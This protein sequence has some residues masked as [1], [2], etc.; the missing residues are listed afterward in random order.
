MNSSRFFAGRLARSQ[1][2][3]RIGREHADRLE[4]ARIEARGLGE[5]QMGDAVAELR[6][7]QQRVAVCRGSA[8]PARCRRG[9]RRRPAG[10]RPPPAG[11]A[12]RPPSRRHSGTAGRPCRR[13]ETARPSVIGRVGKLGLRRLSPASRQGKQRR[14]SGAG[15][16]RDTS[17]SPARTLHEA[18]AV[19]ASLPAARRRQTACDTLPSRWNCA[20]VTSRRT[21]ACA[22][23]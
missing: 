14:Q 20:V 23:L 12:R 7:A 19:L 1:D 6:A 8:A 10:S 22:F 21:S 13:P 5:H 11:R 2:D 18:W 9:R 16:G 15:N 4:R 3:Q 17:A